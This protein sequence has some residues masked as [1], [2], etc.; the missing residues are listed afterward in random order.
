MP[1]VLRCRWGFRFDIFYQ[2]YDQYV[3]KILTEFVF[4]NVCSDPF[5]IK[6]GKRL[7]FVCSVITGCILIIVWNKS[8]KSSIFSLLQSNVMDVVVTG[9]ILI[10]CGL[11]WRLTSTSANLFNR[12]WGVS[13]TSVSGAGRVVSRETLGVDSCLSRFGFEWTYAVRNSGVC[14]W[15]SVASVTK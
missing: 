4:L 12:S 3:L 9:R 10:D 8:S 7:I 6:E 5:R 15:M 11:F 2:E 14:S 1:F 13:G